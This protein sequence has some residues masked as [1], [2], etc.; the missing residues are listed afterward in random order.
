[1]DVF[2]CTSLTWT[3]ISI[4]YQVIRT[5]CTD[6]EMGCI[7][8]SACHETLSFVPRLPGL[9][10][11]QLVYG[12]YLPPPHSLRQAQGCGFPHTQV[13]KRT[14]PSRQSLKKRF[15]GIADEENPTR[16]S[17]TRLRRDMRAYQHGLLWCQK[18]TFISLD[19]PMP[20]SIGAYHHASAINS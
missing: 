6:P 3:Y 8:R 4:C 20:S 16:Y 17:F 5:Y 19:S 18:K 15:H 12:G 13:A 7:G 10:F 9:F 2:F 11:Q 1:M 14:A